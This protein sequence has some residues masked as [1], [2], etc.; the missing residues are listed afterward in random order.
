MRLKYPSVAKLPSVRSNKAGDRQVAPGGL[1]GVR[2][3]RDGVNGT[4]EPFLAMIPPKA[5]AL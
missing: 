3:A 4:L 2:L 5:K 1:C